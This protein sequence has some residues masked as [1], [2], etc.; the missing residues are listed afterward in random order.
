VYNDVQSGGQ[1]DPREP[2]KVVRD[3]GVGGDV[4]ETGRHDPGMCSVARRERKESRARDVHL[5]SAGRG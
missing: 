1:T 4:R 3:A 5:R 2:V